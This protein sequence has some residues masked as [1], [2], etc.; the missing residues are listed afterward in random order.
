MCGELVEELP[1]GVTGR[2]LHPGESTSPPAPTQCWVPQQICNDVR[3]PAQVRLLA[4]F[5]R[6]GGRIP[7]TPPDRR[8][9]LAHRDGRVGDGRPIEA[10]VA[11]ARAAD[12]SG[13]KASRETAVNPRRAYRNADRP[14]M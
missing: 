6:H 4:P 11:R 14:A 5:I 13:K 12:C 10:S 7:R 1:L 8:A 2:A 9:P 3:P